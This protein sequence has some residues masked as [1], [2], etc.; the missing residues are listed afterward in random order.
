MSLNRLLLASIVSLTVFTA[1]AQKVKYKDIYVWLSNKQYDQAAP[2]LKKYV[3]ENDDNPNAFLYMGLIFEDNALKNDALKEANTAISNIDSALLFF[4]KSFQIMSDKELKRNDE[5]YETF[6]RRDLRTGEYGIKLSDIQYFIEKKQQDLKE[7]ADKIKLVSHYFNLSQDLYRNSQALYV[8][9][10][11]RYPST[12][13]LLLRA[14]TPVLDELDALADRF[15]S[16]SKAFDIFRGNLQGLGKSAYQHELELKPIE[17]LSKDGMG[18]TEFLAD[19][20][21]LWDYKSFAEFVSK[22]VKGEVM[23]LKD[24]IVSS[25]IDLNKL[26]ER[27]AADS[28]S[29]RADL[30]RLI[31]KMQHNKLQKFDEN[32]LPSAVFDVKVAEIN[33]KSDVYAAM[34]LRDSANMRMKLALAKTQLSSVR[35]LDSLSSLL[36]LEKVDAGSEDYNHFITSTFGSAVVLKSYVR[37]IQEFAQRERKL[38]EFEVAFREKGVRWLLNGQ[39]SVALYLNPGKDYAYQPL[40]IVEEKHTAGLFFK[41]S[42]TASG[43]FY[44]ITPS[45]KPDVVASFPVEKATYT[46]AMLPFAK[47]F[48]TSD[49]AGQVFFVVIYSEVRAK[50]KVSATVAKIYRSDGLAW[51]NNFQLETNPSAA[52]FVNGELILSSTDGKSWV[53]DKNGKLK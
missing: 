42:V 38:R 40:S 6:K 48:V 7:R 29:V 24:F 33:Y 45:R 15:D 43:Y 41:D 9:I 44:T 17:E 36:T 12:K 19:R 2:F 28:V 50:D 35:A 34:P 46:K 1:Q 14:E 37:G 3:R 10:R 47:S 18:T 4:D 53:L 20:I 30:A 11:N 8:S 26:R 51:S 5:Y 25:D 23:P 39:D 13:S 52:T 16:C 31:P 32:P 22:T 49:A 21:T 27:M